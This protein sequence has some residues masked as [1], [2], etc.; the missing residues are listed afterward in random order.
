MRDKRP[1]LNTQVDSIHAKLTFYLIVICPFSS[2]NLH[3]LFTLSFSMNITT[4][5]VNFLSLDN[6]GVKPSN[7]KFSY[8]VHFCFK[9]KNS[10]M[11][12]T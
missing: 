4:S 3:A 10:Y 12:N 7:V 8:I 9:M 2:L 6:D 11:K 1:T 5:R